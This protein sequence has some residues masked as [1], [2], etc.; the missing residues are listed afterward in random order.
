MSLQLRRVAPCEASEQ[1]LGTV[2]P[3]PSCVASARTHRFVTVAM[4]RTWRLAGTGDGS[5][6]KRWVRCCWRVPRRHG[7]RCA[8][9]SSGCCG[10]EARRRSGE[11]NNWRLSRPCSR[12]CCR[13]WQRVE[14]WSNSARGPRVR[15]F[16]VC[17]RANRDLSGAA[18]NCRGRWAQFER[19]LG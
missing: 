14:A 1:I 15:G 3:V 16:E 5:R 6:S 18:F 17:R 13:R 12:R 8:R 9:Q 19:R 7:R 11:K 4:V 10:G 2:P